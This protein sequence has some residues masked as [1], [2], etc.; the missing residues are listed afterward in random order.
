MEGNFGETTVLVCAI[1]NTEL[2][3]ENIGTEEKTYILSQFLRQYGSYYGILP[4][5][6]DT[7]DFGE[8]WSL[9]IEM[10]GAFYAA[11]VTYEGK[12]NLFY[13]V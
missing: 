7:D 10:K 4:Q 6:I 5:D 11:K 1:I 2:L 8:L 13:V 3:L 9:W 12:D